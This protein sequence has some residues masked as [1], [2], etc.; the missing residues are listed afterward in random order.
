M[1]SL[2]WFLYLAG[3]VENITKVLVLTGCTFL[4]VYVIQVLA[5]A[6]WNDYCDVYK[7]RQTKPYP[8]YKE[9]YIAF[10]F[11]FLVSI[12]PSQNTMYAIAASELGEEVIKSNIGQKS[13]KA[14]EMW[15]DSQ[16]NNVKK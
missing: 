9:V 16:L 4:F 13:I 8:K 7:G 15:I 1:N 6:F 10:V 2:S 14:L 12:I 3:I 11:F 5:V